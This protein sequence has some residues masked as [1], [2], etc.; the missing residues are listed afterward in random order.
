MLLD[1]MRL[2]SYAVLAAALVLVAAY[3]KKNGKNREDKP[4]QPFEA[5][6]PRTQT[7]ERLPAWV[8][9]SPHFFNRDGRR[10]AAAVGG[11]QVKNQ[12][13]ARAAATDRARADLLRLIKGGR[14]ADALAGVLTGARV[15]D[16]FASRMRGQVF[17]RVEVEAARRRGPTVR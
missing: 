3:G 4:S 12:A 16:A 17:V 13:L 7:G 9:E 10:F 8:D 11:A 5:E 14:P 2:G 15:T 6:S 1:A